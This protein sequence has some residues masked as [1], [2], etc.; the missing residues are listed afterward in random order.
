MLQHWWYQATLRAA[1]A[2]D[3]GVEQLEGSGG[4]GGGPPNQTVR[5]ARNYQ[6]VRRTPANPTSQEL[7]LLEA[8]SKAPQ[9]HNG[10]NKKN[11]NYS[12]F[13]PR[14]V[15]AAS[16]PGAQWSESIG[17]GGHDA[18]T[19]NAFIFVKY[20]T[21][22]FERSSI[23]LI[24]KF[25]TRITLYN[26]FFNWKNVQ[27]CIFSQIFHDR[28]LALTRSAVRRGVALHFNGKVYN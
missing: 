26:S 23:G 1:G 17:E 13:P 12:L 11:N 6:T 28:L 5:R 18:V 22:D 20:A 19:L 8:S 25:P 24:V 15:A 14:R 16:C 3:L 10:H 9:A 21:Q 7:K 27:I 2:P 4:G